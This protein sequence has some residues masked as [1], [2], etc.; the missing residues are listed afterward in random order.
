V[1]DGSI[2]IPAPPAAPARVGLYTAAVRPDIGDR[3]HWPMGI[4]FRPEATLG[5]ELLDGGA[6]WEDCPGGVA[7]DDEAAKTGGPVNPETVTYRPWQLVEGETCS[8]VVHNAADYVGRARRRI[9]ANA[10]RKLEREFLLG[11][12]TQAGNLGNAYLTDAAVTQ[13]LGLLP[14]VYALGEL[15]TYLADTIPGRGMIHCTPRTATLWL[16]AFVIRREGPVYLDVMDNVVVVGAGYTGDG[17]DGGEPAVPGTVE[18]AYATGLV[19][20]LEAD[21]DLYPDNIAE[22]TDKARNE[23]TYRAEEWVA[24]FHDGEAQAGIA[25]DLCNTCCTTGS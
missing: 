9:K 24:T 6:W 5:A 2:I 23:V 7:P 25:V 1:A 13:D 4:R 3:V 19:Q 16:S 14:L 11:E 15:Q 12:I 18:W 10:G 21:V 20:L 17:P 8:A 22:A